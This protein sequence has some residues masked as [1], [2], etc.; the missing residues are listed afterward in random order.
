MVWEP[1]QIAPKSWAEVVT[2]YEGIEDRNHDFVPL[3]QLGQHVAGQGYATSIA[4]ATSGTALLVAPVGARGIVGTTEWA[5]GALRV[6]IDL[7]GSVRFAVP[8]GGQRSPRVVTLVH[9]TAAIATFERLLR[10]AGCIE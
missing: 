5:A 7:S 2:F 3:R 10:D 8:A 9:N 1:S 6:D 4:A